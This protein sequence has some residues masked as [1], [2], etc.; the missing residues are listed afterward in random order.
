MMNGNRLKIKITRSRGNKGNL[1]E[2]SMDKEPLILPDEYFF[3]LALI[4]NKILE[5]KAE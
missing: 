3:N 4:I 5:N 1:N 2:I